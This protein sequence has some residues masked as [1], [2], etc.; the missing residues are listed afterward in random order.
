MVKFFA[1]MGRKGDAMEVAPGVDVVV[2]DGVS[3][4]LG[5]V[6]GRVAVATGMDGPMEGSGDTEARGI[7]GYTGG[8]ITM[9]GTSGASRASTAFICPT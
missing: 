8:V 6:S 9:T 5:V 7:S 2:A 3:V 4:G 1:E